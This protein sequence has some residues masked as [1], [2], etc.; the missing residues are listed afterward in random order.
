MSV[1]VRQR[2]WSGLRV[3]GTVK[4]KMAQSGQKWHRR[5]CRLQHPRQRLGAQWHLFRSWKRVEPRR[6]GA[7]GAPVRSKEAGTAGAKLGR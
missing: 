1:I 7:L 3:K 2:V 5:L 4:S 6:A